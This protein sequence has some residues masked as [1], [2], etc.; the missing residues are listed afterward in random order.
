[1]RMSA[2]ILVVLAL[3]NGQAAE[4][5]PATV[6]HLGICMARGA[7]TGVELR[8]RA[9][10]GRIFAEIGIGIEW[11]CSSSSQKTITIVISTSTPEKN[12]PGALA[13]AQ[14]SAGRILVFCDRVRKSSPSMWA[15]LLAY[16]IAHEIGH[17]LQG[18]ARHSD[19]GIMKA[20]WN[21]QD[22]RQMLSMDLKFT[23]DDV[24]LIHRGMDTDRSRVTEPLL[25]RVR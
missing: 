17:V 20:Y 25:T 8:G 18:T 14:P 13:Y 19:R 7:D 23:T 10:A 21:D 6:R 22:F 3:M 9:L 5:A 12:S 1:M 11:H 2:V 24:F 16:V 4:V 15:H